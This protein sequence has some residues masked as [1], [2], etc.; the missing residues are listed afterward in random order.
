M[1]SYATLAQLKAYLKIPT[2]NT[3]EDTLLQAFLDEASA[4]LD[5]VIGRPSAAAARTARTFDAVADV[6]GRLLMFDCDHC[7]GI[8]AVVNGDGATIDSADYVTEPRNVGPFWGIR[9]KGGADAVWTF[10]DSPEGAI[11]VTA[12][13]AYTTNSD[14]TADAL[15]VGACRTLAA[16]LYREKDNMGKL[17]ETADG[18]T[19]VRAA[20]PKAIFDRVIERRRIV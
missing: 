12:Y 5:E 6:D 16:W 2:G 18:V 10:E 19:V 4:I 3:G 8:S 20:L 7:V 11:S 15:I 13:W 17:V 14:G 1:S 9:L